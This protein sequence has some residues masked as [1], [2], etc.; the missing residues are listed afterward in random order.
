MEVAGSNPAAPTNQANQVDTASGSSA[1]VPSNVHLPVACEL[2]I[3]VIEIRET[4]TF[5]NLASEDAEKVALEVCGG[6]NPRIQPT[7]RIG[8]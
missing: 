2:S 7:E 1:P 4:E 8:L 6:F 5:S 3:L